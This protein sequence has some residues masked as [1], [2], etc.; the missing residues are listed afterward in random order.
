MRVFFTVSTIV[1]VFVS[2]GLLLGVPSPPQ[3]PA[4]A[5]PSIELP[6]GEGKQE[7]QTQCTVCHDL[8]RVV[9]QKK[10]LEAWQM[11]VADMLGRVSPG[12]E[13]ETVIISDYLAAHYGVVT[14]DVLGRV[15]A[16]LTQGDVATANGLVRDNVEPLRD[17]LD[18]ILEEMDRG[19]DE[20]G[21][22]KARYD[23]LHE[24]FNQFETTW[25]QYE[26]VFRLFSSVTDHAGYMNHFQAKRLRVE[27]AG[28][29]T[30]AD[31]FWDLQDYETAIR[32][33][34]EG[35]RKLREAISL[36]ESAGDRKLVAASLTNIGYNEIYSG[37]SATGLEVYTQALEIAEQRQDEI[38][39]GMYLLNLGTFH[40][41]TMQSEEALEFALRAEEMN[42][43]IGRRTWHANA[44]LNVGVSYLSLRKLEEADSYLQ[45][46]L[47][48]AEEA[49]DQRSHGRILY[50]LALVHSMFGRTSQSA[51]YM[52]DALEW[53][54]GHPIVYNDAERTML[55]YHGAL[56][57][58]RAYRKLNDSE[59]VQYYADQA[60]ELRS[61]DPQKLAT[62][63]VDPHL[64]YLKWDDFKK[65]HGLE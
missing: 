62:Y 35:T 22:Q 56:Y 16:S 61:R 20:L 60:S 26:S 30:S 46:A 58:A 11:T 47:L 49:K 3:I 24:K 2:Y 32:E 19:F 53:Y 48:K 18:R 38:F 43:K 14:S 59:K 29:T 40:L 6:D 23:V 13:K 36:A 52:E 5:T 45:K 10:S 12:L 57:L 27:G 25:M 55:S 28:H 44:L 63:L 7:V 31:H 54:A 65:E 4:N 8:E 17:E 39:Q 34:S 1:F 42:A 64:N 9:N 51:S 41:Y 37:N 33:Y 50:N 15:L 21:R